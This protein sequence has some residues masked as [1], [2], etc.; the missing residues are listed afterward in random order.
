MNKKLRKQILE[1]SLRAKSVPIPEPRVRVEKSDG[2]EVTYI[3]D[4]VCLRRDEKTKRIE[5]ISTSRAFNLFEKQFIGLRFP[6]D[7]AH[8]CVS[9]YAKQVLG[10]LDGQY[11]DYEIIT[12]LEKIS[13][14]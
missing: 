8:E 13:L 12:G 4:I 9:F 3:E 14:D 11:K 10:K 1:A 6:A 5:A 7:R 2:V